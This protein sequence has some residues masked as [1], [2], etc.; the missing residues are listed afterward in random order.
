MIYYIIVLIIILIMIY[1][2][3]NICIFDHF[4]NIDYRK[5]RLYKNLKCN[6]E[7][8]NLSKIQLIHKYIQNN[9][10]GKITDNSIIK[11][12]YN[13][14]KPCYYDLHKLKEIHIKNKKFYPFKILDN[15]EHISTEGPTHTKGECYFRNDTDISLY[16]ET[17]PSFNLINKDVIFR[18]LNH[19]KLKKSICDNKNLFLED[20]QNLSNNIYY[21]I[22]LKTNDNLDFDKEIFDI[23][24]QQI[25][26]VKYNNNSFLFEP[27][28]DT[29]NQ[30]EKLFSLSYDT[31]SIYFVPRRIFVTFLVFS[32]NICNNYVLE[33][34]FEKERFDLSMLGFKNESLKYDSNIDFNMQLN[35]DND[36]YN[37]LS[38]DYDLEQSKDKINTEIDSLNKNIINNKQ[39]EYQICYNKKARESHQKT[40]EKIKKIKQ[41]ENIRALE[42]N[43]KRIEKQILDINKFLDGIKDNNIDYN[44]EHK[45]MTHCKYKL[46]NKTDIKALYN[47]FA[48]CQNN[49]D[50]VK[51][52]ILNENEI[53]EYE[54]DN[55]ESEYLKTQLDELQYQINEIQEFKDYVDDNNL[56]TNIPNNIIHQLNDYSNNITNYCNINSS[57]GK[58][59]LEM[60]ENL[61]Y[62]S[63]IIDNAIIPTNLITNM[64]NNKISNHLLKYVSDDDCIY[65]FINQ[66]IT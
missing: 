63:S 45:I 25:S 8:S 23:L 60:Q 44:F 65:F 40:I 26:T 34:K 51:N 43:I 48:K 62:I 41:R 4:E 24:F 27:Y 42:N 38:S 39:K 31:N 55:I 30:L 9:K 61:S 54:I 32:K 1:F 7:Y 64:K 19:D 37:L 2:I 3:D 10:D 17:D 49:L 47:D 58:T 52:R 66:N 15:P 11:N 33:E 36:V 56:K 59:I 6:P 22:Q 21:K 57:K 28:N 14:P 16:K 18:N 5:C 20:I 53:G 13:N 29:N 12:I 50:K 35:Q 46:N